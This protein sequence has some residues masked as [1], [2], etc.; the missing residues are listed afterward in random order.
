MTAQ[1]NV[2]MAVILGGSVMTVLLHA[3][4]LT[5][6]YVKAIWQE[7]L[8]LQDVQFVSQAG[9]HPA[10]IVCY[11]VY[12]AA[13][14]QV[15]KRAVELQGSALMDVPRDGTVTRVPLSVVL[16]VLTVCV[17]SSTVTVLES[18]PQVCMAISVS[19][20]VQ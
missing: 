6:I 8:F 5:V 20:S 16:T 12:T 9:I 7:V 3:T 2:N 13:P 4:Y 19:T 1:G 17:T 15:Q 10:P 18:V 14:H 11:V